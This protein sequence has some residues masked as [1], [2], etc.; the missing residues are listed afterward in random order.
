MATNTTNYNLILPAPN[1]PTDQDIWGGYLNTNFVSIDTLLKSATFTTTAA[2]SSNTVL[3]TTYIN[4]VVLVDATSGNLTITLPAVATAGAGFNLAVVKIDAS[5]NTVTVDGDGSETINGATTQVIS[6]QYGQLELVT[7][8]TVW[9]AGVS[10]TLNELLPNQTGN[11]G[12]FLITDGANTSW[13]NAA[14]TF[15]HVVNKYASGAAGP[16][17]GA[18]WS[19][20]PM[21]NLLVNT[22]VG[23]SY[24]ANQVTLPAG[25]YKAAIFGTN[26]S[27]GGAQARLRNITDSTTTI[28]GSVGF[29]LNVGTGSF[30]AEINQQS[31]AEGVFTIN[32]T[33]VFELQWAGGGTAR[34]FTFGDD[35]LAASMLFTKVG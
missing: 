11:S 10:K 28:I 21:T 8:G 20:Y 32:S 18:T 31:N 16:T 12:K 17:L 19:T 7:N 29:G 22:I 13:G 27:A 24:A 30:L 35:V 2:L 23:A 9:Y 34:T 5:A 25:T 6:S 15:L 14:Q 26:D 3:D 1:D 33:K 4:K